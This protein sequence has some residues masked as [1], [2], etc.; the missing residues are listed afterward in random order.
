LIGADGRPALGE[1][2]VRRLAEAPRLAAVSLRRVGA[3][4]HWIGR[5]A[6]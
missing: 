5:L 2:G 3:D 4:A 6:P 1:L